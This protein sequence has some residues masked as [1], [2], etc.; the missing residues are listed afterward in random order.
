LISYFLVHLIFN[1]KRDFLARFFALFTFLI[2]DQFSP[3]SFCLSS[4][5]LFNFFTMRTLPTSLL[6]LCVAHL[7]TSKRGGGGSFHIPSDVGSG[8]GGS[9]SSGGSSGVPYTPPPPPC[10]EGLCTCAMISERENIYELPGLYYNGTITVTHQLT[11]NPAWTAE[12][13]TTRAGE[14]CDNN[15]HVLKTY[16]YPALFFIGPKGNASDTNPVFWAL[17]GFQPPDQ[18]LNG[19]SLDVYQRWVHV[20][21]SDFV[22]TDDSLASQFFGQ[23][24]YYDSDETGFHQQTRVYWDTNV[25]TS[26]QNTWSASATYVNAPPELGLENRAFGN[27]PAGAKPRSSQYVTLSDVCYYDYE[28]WD[29]EVS[30]VASSYIPAGGN[31]LWTTTPT[32]FLPLGSS[33]SITNIGGDSLSFQLNSTLANSVSFVSVSES[34]CAFGPSTPRIPFKNTFDLLHWRQAQAATSQ[35]IWN[36]SATVGLSFEGV[37]VKENSTVINGTQNGAP[38]FGEVYERKGKDNFTTGSAKSGAGKVYVSMGSI[39]S[40]AMVVGIGM[41]VLAR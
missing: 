28:V 11:G 37:I 5:A 6:L 30:L 13:T 12:A 38:T 26:D 10:D 40:I 29:S 41:R 19:P 4:V 22:V 8:S 17:R 39:V 35:Y 21:S 20:R 25:T 32:L 15:D 34:T 14:K 9:G 24:Q 2:P 16:T 23:Y 1:V 36:V 18:Q 31:Y 33:A 7:T 27:P 3:A